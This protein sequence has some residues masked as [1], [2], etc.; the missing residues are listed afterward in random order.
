MLHGGVPRGLPGVMLCCWPRPAAPPWDAAGA[1]SMGMSGKE[2]PQWFFFIVFSPLRHEGLFTSLQ[3]SP[4][5][6][7]TLVSVGRGCEA[8]P[9]GLFSS[10][11]FFFPL[12][13][14]CFLKPP[15]AH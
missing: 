14:V 11:S 13:L 10:F 9:L 6:L 12:S 4:C 5:A 7:P 1:I 8:V 15:R 2:A 3:T